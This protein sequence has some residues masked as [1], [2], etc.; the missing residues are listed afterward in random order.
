MRAR[1]L[2]AIA[3]LS[4]AL[5]GA[6]AVARAG[7]EKKQIEAKIAEAMSAYDNFDYEKARTVLNQALLVSKK[8]KLGQDKITAKIHLALGVIYL[9]GFEDKD[10]AKV[11]FLDAVAIDPKVQIDPAYKTPEL[12]KLLEEARKDSGGSGKPPKDPPPK[13]PPPKDPPPKDPPEVAM[14]DDTDCASLVGID[15]DLVDEA[16]PGQAK[17]IV[18]HVAD[19]LEPAKVALHYRAK[20]AASFQEV[21]MT[22]DS[23]CRYKATIPKKV[24]SS[25][26][27]HYF[28]A[29]YDKGGKIVASKG[30]SGSPNII[31]VAG[32]TAGDD[33][34]DDGGENPLGPGDGGIT[35][36]G[37]PL[38]K[39]S[40]I[41][42][43]LAAG[44][45]GGYVSGN[46]EQLES[47][48][49]CCFAPA[50]LHLFPEVG[51]FFS[52]QTS[53]SAALRLG[54]PIGANRMGH[55]GPAVGGLVRVRHAFSPTGEGV[56]VNGGMGAGIIR[57]TVKLTGVDDGT[58]D[59]DTS[60]S[61]PLF[62]GTGAG[63]LRSLG[64]PMRFI[65][66]LNVIA[67]IPVAKVGEIDP[68]FALQIDAN[69]GIVV[70][71]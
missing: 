10:S 48:V 59:T 29:A 8:A 51:F 42:I 28:V 66:E 67:G 69:L 43:S 31:E 71:F 49:G 63:Y 53:V 1:I 52:R 27:V 24:F 3:A 15:H 17:P 64:G 39:A 36:P 35:K 44:S 68:G 23:G 6:P 40:K 16:K 19:T 37:G 2:L 13:D 54:F 58:G 55:A 33:D 46:T 50:L 18:V 60:A 38:P 14:V 61:G 20:G 9:A 12:D 21:K 41:F 4:F 30:S 32:M 26:F 5:V 22:R 11:Y 25:E 47:P 65:A 62:I 57:H 70:A 34:D 45:G 56:V 7:D